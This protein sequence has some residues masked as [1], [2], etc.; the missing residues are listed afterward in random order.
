MWLYSSRKW[1]WGHHTYLNALRSAALAISMLRKMRLCSA[2]GSWSR[3]NCGTN[4]WANTPNSISVS[5]GGDREHPAVEL[6]VVQ[7]VDGPL[8]L[9]ERVD[10]ADHLVEQQ[11]AVLVEADQQRDVVVGPGGAVAAAEDRLVVVEVVDHEA[12]LGAELGHAEQ[13][14]RAAPVEQVDALADEGRVADAL[15]H[16]VGAVG[17]A[18]VLDR[19]DGVVGAAGVDEVGGAEPAGHG[20]LV[21]VGVDHH[22]AA[23]GGDAGGLDRALADPAGAD[24]HHGLAGA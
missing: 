14:E 7:V 9:V 5:F 15:E 18:E 12:G 17:Q 13:G 22:D 19:G 23:G 6:A 11:A 10:L 3:S 1:C 21:G 24:D 8:D 20:L 4:S 2:R 16:V